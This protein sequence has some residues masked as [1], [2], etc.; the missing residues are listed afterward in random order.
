M[1]VIMHRIQTLAL[2]CMLAAVILPG[3]PALADS[4]TGAVIYVSPD[5]SDSGTGGLAD[6]LKTIKGARDKIRSIKRRGAYPQD[7]ITVVFRAGE[8]PWSET[9]SFTNADS[10]TAERPIVYRSYPGEQVYFTG[11]AKAFGEEFM[12]VSDP[13]VAA[14]LPDPGRVREIDIKAVFARAGYEGIAD[15]QYAQTFDHYDMSGTCRK[16][17]L[18]AAEGQAAPLRRPTYSF[19]GEQALWLARYPN[20]AGG[21]YAQENP[22]TVF[23]KTRVDESMPPNTFSYANQTP[24]TIQRISSYAGRGDVYIYGNL[25][26]AFWHDEDRAQIDPESKTISA[27]T[28]NNGVRDNMP[29]LLMNILEELDQQGEYYI[30]TE[31]GKMYVYREDFSDTVLNVAMFDKA[32]M[33]TAKDASFITFQGITFE[34]TKGSVASIAGGDSVRFAD[35]TFSN[36]GVTAVSIGENQGKVFEPRPDDSTISVEEHAQAQYRRWMAPEKGTAATGRN[37]GLERCI[38][39]NTGA[40]AVWLS[41]G[42]VYR[43]EECGYFVRN[44]DIQYAGVHKRTYSGA[45]CLNE[46]FGAYIENNALS[47]IPGAVINGTAYKLLI[48][49]N[50]IFDGM[51]ESYDNA[52]VYLN[53]QT[54]VLDIRFEG[55]YFHD[56][57]SDV[58]LKTD[59]HWP[60]PQRGA[61]AFDNAPAGGGYEYVNNI[62]ANLPY[63]VWYANGTNVSDNLFINCY[64]PVKGGGK[65]AQPPEYPLRASW[66]NLADD[67][68][69]GTRFRDGIGDNSQSMVTYKTYLSMPIFAGDTND[70]Q[71]IEGQFR[72]RWYRQYPSMMNWM[73][74]TEKGTCGE[75]GFMQVKDNLII[76]TN[77]GELYENHLTY[78]HFTPEELAG[79]TYTGPEA[80]YREI[81]GN[82]YTSQTDMLADYANGNYE[83]TA[84]GYGCSLSLSQVGPQGTAGAAE[85]TAAEHPLPAETEGEFSSLRYGPTQMVNISGRDLLLTY[86]DRVT[87]LVR[88]ADGEIRHID[89]TFA[90]ITGA[91]QF[92]FRLAGDVS[93]YTLTV[94]A[95]GRLLQGNIITTQSVND[96]IQPVFTMSAEGGAVTLAMTA[97]NQYLAEYPYTFLIAGYNEQGKLLEMKPVKAGRG[98]ISGLT[99]DSCTILLDS[100]FDQTQLAAVR[101]LRAYLWDSVRGMVPLAKAQII[102]NNL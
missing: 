54:P 61:V 74:L 90:D 62:F 23:L 4:P 39:Q 6:P 65:A 53:Y 80:M 1:K 17:P 70:P 52:L 50:E 94:N 96:I 69:T 8:Y 34:N 14:R 91:Y 83:I 48:K 21:A 60:G 37:H 16:T 20:K 43:D 10:G 30:D 57:P 73:D 38:I 86:T 66:A 55:N 78:Y 100:V 82:V 64:N 59:R 76:N 63:G 15:Y 40:N 51:T 71:S 49:S 33:L 88:D 67:P 102:E 87:L 97:D 41:G 35:C 99:E 42:N 31:T 44:C 58:E 89:Q 75:L 81:S 93:D 101:F 36:I 9:I 12:T 72:E 47:H 84:P 68:E 22:L 32:Y 3:P 27:P 46:V 25:C 18:E 29:F 5:G 19:A 26:Y 2:C 56:V 7:G 98:E 79:K 85:Y 11:G 77:D 28:L 13:A 24:E 95:G 92:T 45:I